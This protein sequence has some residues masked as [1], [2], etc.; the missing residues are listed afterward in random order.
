MMYESAV[1]TGGNE[2]EVFIK[3]NKGDLKEFFREE[4]ENLK[5][6]NFAKEI[7]MQLKLLAEESSEAQD[8]INSILQSLL[9]K[10]SLLTRPQLIAKIVHLT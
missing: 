9:Q 1:A 10:R 6:F 2:F 3:M 8:Q 4:Y 7:L 5:A